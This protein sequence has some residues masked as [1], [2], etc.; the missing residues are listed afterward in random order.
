M[1]QAVSDY[2]DKTRERYPDK[3]AYAD[4]AREVTFQQLYDEAIHVADALVSRDLFKSPVLLY[5]DKSVS[6]ISCFTG[7]AYS[8][9]L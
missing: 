7:V 6:L 9:N 5:M 2:L 3:L 8:G 4:N 1:I